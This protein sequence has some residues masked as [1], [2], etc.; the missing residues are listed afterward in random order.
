MSLY[1]NYHQLSTMITDLITYFSKMG[2]SRTLL[3]LL[4]SGQCFTRTHHREN[5]DGQQLV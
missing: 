2:Q 3:F 4:L 5:I 1:T